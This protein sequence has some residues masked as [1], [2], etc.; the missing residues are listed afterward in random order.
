MGAVGQDA[1][2]CLQSPIEQESF[3]GERSVGSRGGEEEA[4]DEAEHDA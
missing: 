3:F 1:P 4:D 2:Q